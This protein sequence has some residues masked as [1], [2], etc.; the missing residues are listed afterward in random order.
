[1]RVRSY[2]PFQ[3]NANGSN[4]KKIQ[5][6]FPKSFLKLSKKA[7]FHC[8]KQ[9]LSISGVAGVELSTLAQRGAQTLNVPRTHARV[10]GDFAAPAIHL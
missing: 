10:H 5:C 4:S 2:F 9:N 1:M 8:P 6:K 3:F 7:I